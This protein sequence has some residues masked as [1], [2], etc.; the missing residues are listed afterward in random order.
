MKLI[1]DLGTEKDPT[2]DS[3]WKLTE[4][5][6]STIQVITD[7]R[8]RGFGPMTVYA[9]GIVSKEVLS[10][11]GGPSTTIGQLKLQIWDALGRRENQQAFELY[12]IPSG[13]ASKISY[14]KP[15][16]DERQLA[17][18]EIKDQQTIYFVPAT[19]TRANW[20]WPKYLLQRKET[21]GPFPKAQLLASPEFVNEDVHLVLL[22]YR[23]R[24]VVTSWDEDFAVSH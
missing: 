3:A 17:H 16:E 7:H 19:V 18:Y 6:V 8:D 1:P 13:I 14:D 15:L 10:L 4:S 12:N 9:N 24:Q 23:E 22:R 5:I 11:Q 21:L 2:P 20:N